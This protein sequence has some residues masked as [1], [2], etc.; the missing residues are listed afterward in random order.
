M[1]NMRKH[2]IIILL[3]LL[4]ADITAQAQGLSVIGMEAAT[5]DISGSQYERKDADGKPC[6]LIK[7]RL[8]AEGAH[9]IGNVI[10]PVENKTG[11][12]WAYMPAGSK[13]MNIM[14]PDKTTLAVTF[15]DY[16]IVLQPRATYLLTL[17]QEGTV[18]TGSSQ[19]YLVL[20][21]LP[22]DCRISMDGQVLTAKDG[23]G[24]FQI[25]AGRHS[26]HIE[27][28]GWKAVDTTFTAPKDGN[29]HMT[30]ILKRD[31]RQKTFTANG[32]TFRVNKVEFGSFTM[33]SEQEY[34]NVYLAQTP[35]QV[36]IE[37]TFYMGETEVT[38]ELWQAVMGSN[39]SVSKG[40]NKPVTNIT[41]DDCYAFC[42]QLFK[43]TGEKFRVPTEEEWEYAARGG[44]SS[45]HTPYSGSDNKNLVSWNLE[46]S[47]NMLHD[48]AL[49]M[50]NE[51]GLYD[52][53]GNATELAGGFVRGGSY[54]EDSMIMLRSWCEKTKKELANAQGLRIVH[55]PKRNAFDK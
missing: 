5:F 48:V 35:R 27:A 28:E 31:V 32:V 20:S 23:K 3:T 21:V 47:G 7:V 36:S 16:G 29:K 12:Y 24:M 6:A 4:A 43:L 53:S 18:L 15:S 46:N 50:P 13:R 17:Q 54:K 40:P 14:L 26:C 41:P 39:P 49:L 9:F 2:I 45:S 52:M 44:N 8:A 34:A 10:Q 51:L 11:E 42:H 55:D 38:Q 19:Q 33:G 25:T 1:R 22:Q 37:R 30:V